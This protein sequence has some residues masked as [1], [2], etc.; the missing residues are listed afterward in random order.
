VNHDAVCLALHIL[1]IR[2]VC[3][4]FLTLV[5]LYEITKRHSP[6][7]LNLYKSGC[8]RKKFA[9]KY[10]LYKQSI[11]IGLIIANGK[12]RAGVFVSL[13]CKRRNKQ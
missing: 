8:E 9:R 12:K 7:I 11:Y 4:P 1:K 5:K 2:G 10:I 6:E 3:A 13:T